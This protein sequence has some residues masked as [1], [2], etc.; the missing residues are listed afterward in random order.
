MMSNT[1][2]LIQEIEVVKLTQAALA[3]V[4]AMCM[5][6]DGNESIDWKI[7][8]SAIV[9]RWSKSA[10]ERVLTMAWKVIEQA[11]HDALKGAE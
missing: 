5:M 8:N 10:R 9:K 7:V 2:L 4:M 1:E 11:K 6:Q 3:Q